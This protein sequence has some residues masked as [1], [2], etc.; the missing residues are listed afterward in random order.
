MKTQIKP[1]VVWIIVAVMLVVVAIAWNRGTR[2]S[3]PPSWLPKPGQGPAAP[4]AAPP[5]TAP[6][7]PK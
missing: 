2:P 3:E 1:L 6:V 5:T 7:P 4:P